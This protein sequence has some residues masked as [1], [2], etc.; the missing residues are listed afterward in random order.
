MSEARTSERVPRDRH[1][2]MTA[3]LDTV[4]LE[5]TKVQKQVKELQEQLEQNGTSSLMM[6]LNKIQKGRG[7]WRTMALELFNVKQLKG[8][9]LKKNV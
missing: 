3:K 8:Y 5:M 7:K 9:I 6:H 2:I 1:D 4:T